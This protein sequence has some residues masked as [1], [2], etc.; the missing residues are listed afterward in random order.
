MSEL[1]KTD[2]I[3]ITGGSGFCGIN[4][5]RH[6]HKRG[7]YNIRVIDL[8]NFDYEDV[9]KKIEFIWGD[10]RNDKEMERAYKGIKYVI[11]CAA[12][13]PTCTK[14]EIISTEINGTE[15]VLKFALK[16]KVRRVINISTGA[17]YGIPDHKP[18]KEE[19][20]LKPI[21]AYAIAKVQAE[22][23]CGIYRE[24]GLIVST[25]R[26]APIE[27]P[28]R[29]GIMSIL[30]DWVCKKKN[31]PIIGNGKNQYQLLDVE[32]FCDVVLRC[33]TLNSKKVNTTFNL[34]TNKYTTIKEDFEEVLKY[35]NTGKRVICIPAKPLN[36]ILS[37]LSF[38]RLSPIYKWMYESAYKDNI[39]S[40]ER[41]KKLL[42]F[43]P[44][45][46][47]KETLVRGYKSY[48]ENR[49][50]YTY[51]GV[52]HRVPWKQGILKFISLFF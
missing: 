4:L 36:I 41:A 10:I 46:S 38:L 6:L 35:A 43:K 28:E 47:N 32:D 30:Y 26:T 23:I 49:N 22:K 11:H 40:I 1:K 39:F 18:L 2:T 29:M 17:V 37:V 9:N 24:K 12:A 15:N 21:G 48:I 16:Y 45:Y 51:V 50:K 31:I 14:E 34:G 44:K 13:L 20:L 52:T 3:L 42:G 5:V 33:M 19:D 27:G 25:L 8:V 7:C